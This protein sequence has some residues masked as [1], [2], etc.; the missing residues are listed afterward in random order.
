MLA[1]LAVLGAGCAHHQSVARTPAA[2]AP[3]SAFE[4]QIRNA[5]DAGDGDYQLRVLRDKVAAS[6]DDPGA[7]VQLAAAYR[8]RGYPDIA[9]EMSRLAAARFPHSGEVELALVRALRDLNQRNEAIASLEAFLQANPQTSP[10]YFSWIGILHDESGQWAAGEAS[11]RKAIELAASDDSLHNNLGYNLLMQKKGP[12]AVVEFREALRLN[13][14][15]ETARNNLGM[16]L[17][18]QD[19]NAQAV[20]NW[21]SASDAATAHNNL[22]AVLIE[23]GNFAEA[24]NELELALRYNRAH[25]AA[26]KNMELVSRLDG[27]AATMPAKQAETT[28][29]W[30]RWKTGFARLFVGPLEDTRTR[31]Q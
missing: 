8:D 17:A 27:N 1:G 29:R 6:P 30:E 21:Q 10:A 11:H 3:M 5:H 2:P 9:L 26:L 31:P 25:P 7:R 18:S 24:R 28:T 13:P 12:E 23:R 15:S 19:S 14:G 20:A 4:R 22:A 16:A